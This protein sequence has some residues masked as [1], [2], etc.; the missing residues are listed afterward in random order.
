M[1]RQISGG[2]SC[3]QVTGGTPSFPYISPGSAGAGMVR[4]NPNMNCLEINDGSMWKTLNVDYTMI[5]LTPSAEA[6]IHWAQKKMNEERDLEELCK[7][8]PGLEKARNN[9]EM[10]KRLAESTLKDG[11]EAGQVQTGP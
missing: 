8:F 3:I 7:R 11:S 9:F 1:I 2:G 6:A 10:F 4:W 5:S